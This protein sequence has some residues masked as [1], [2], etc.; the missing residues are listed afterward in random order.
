MKKAAK[1]VVGVLVVA[2]IAWAGTSWYVGKRVEQEL[3]DYVS[4]LQSQPLPW[5]L[6][7]TGYDRGWFSSDVRM[8]LTVRDFPVPGVLAPGDVVPIHAHVQHGPF[9][10]S[11][12]TSGRF[13]P[14]LA[15]MHTQL[16]N[17]GAAAAWFSSAKG[18]PPLQDR[19]ALTFAGDITGQATFAPLALEDDGTAVTFDGGTI[20]YQASG[21]A[22][23]VLAD[24]KLGNIRIKSAAALGVADDVPADMMIEDTSFDVDYEKGKFDI[25][26]GKAHV[27]LGRITLESVDEEGQPLSIVL[28]DY[29]LDTQ[30]GEDEQNLNARVD[31]SIGGMRL[32]GMDLGQ[33]AAT[34]RVGSLN[35]EAMRGIVSRYRE[36]E[37][38]LLAEAQAMDPQSGKFPP[39]LSAFLEESLNALLPGKPSFGLDPARWTLPGGESSVRLNVTLREAPEAG[40]A[41]DPLQQVQSLD[42]SLVISRGMVLDLIKTASASGGAPAATLE[43]Q[44]AEAESTYA[45][46]RQMALSTGYLVQ[47]GE[48]LVMRV[49]YTDGQL[50]LNG[51]QSGLEELLSALQ[52]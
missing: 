11:R 16:E 5:D 46:L 9:P 32:M 29:V 50:R 47:E 14:V 31:Y 38:E 36:I 12:L 7:V 19:S 42:G 28:Q 33:M 26:L 45:F 10:L 49:S 30:V 3:R 44:Q 23:R 34:M 1:A 40:D 48:N 4:S 43:Q 51:E 2:G 24:A 21:D 13:G 37:P 52:R 20:D 22:A 25:Y 41:P 17:S 35:G 27:R 39:K 18:Q 15:A 8:S 6:A